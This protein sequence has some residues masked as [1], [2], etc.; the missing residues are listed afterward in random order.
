MISIWYRTL[1]CERKYLVLPPRKDFKFSSKKN[2][3]LCISVIK[4]LQSNKVQPLETSF[5]HQWY[6]KEKKKVFD[7]NLHKHSHAECKHLTH[8]FAIILVGYV[9]S[10]REKSLSMS[11]LSPILFEYLN[12]IFIFSKSFLGR[13]TSLKYSQH[14]YTWKKCHV[15]PLKA[16]IDYSFTY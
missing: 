5:T 1:N 12:L 11:K 10:Q 8:C 16:N 2:N 4:V 3:C 6:F 7:L 13:P 9:V 15:S 14:F